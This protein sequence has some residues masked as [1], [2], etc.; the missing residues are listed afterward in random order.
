MSHRFHNSIYS[1]DRGLHD[2]GSRRHIMMSFH[3]EA[4][5]QQGLRYRL[6]EER[7][8]VKGCSFIGAANEYLLLIIRCAKPSLSYQVKNVVVQ[9][10]RVQVMDTALP[11]SCSSA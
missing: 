4:E 2:R 8:R 1:R 10:L 3:H 11:E 9:D 6:A 5:Y 7:T